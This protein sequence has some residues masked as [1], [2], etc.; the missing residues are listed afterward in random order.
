M[1]GLPK[2]PPCPQRDKKN[3]ELRSHTVSTS[4]ILTAVSCFLSLTNRTRDLMS[5]GTCLTRPSQ[6]ITS[7]GR[8][9]GGFFSRVEENILI[10]VNTYYILL[11]SLR[12]RLFHWNHLS[13][14]NIH[15]QVLLN[16]SRPQPDQI[17][18]Q[19]SFPVNVVNEFLSPFQPGSTHNQCRF[20]DWRRHL[21]QTE[22]TSLIIKNT[23]RL[24]TRE[25]FRDRSCFP[26]FQRG[27]FCI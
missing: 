25:I 15:L 3:H 14:H 24:E 6:Q 12:I 10:C 22:E 17:C 13:M 2:L 27:D 5:A 26:G 18:Y 20:D 1:N 4:H 19:G 8:S 7:L 21:L 16:T 11:N 9:Y 23:T